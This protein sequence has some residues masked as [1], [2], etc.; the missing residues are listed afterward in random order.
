MQLDG[1]WGDHVTLQVRLQTAAGCS[2]PLQALPH[3]HSRALT[4][5]LALQALSDA[6]G[7][8]V[9]VLTSFAGSEF[10]EILPA[11]GKVRAPRS[12]YVSFW[13]EV[14]HAVAAER[15]QGILQGK[16]GQLVS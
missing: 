5:P 3:K 15:S 7:I 13:A 14:S 8:R 2:E 11:D 16:A 4:L 10:I 6:L 1:T 12:L 9:V